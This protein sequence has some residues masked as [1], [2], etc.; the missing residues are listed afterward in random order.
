MPNNCNAM[1]WG[2]CERVIYAL[3]TRWNELT[4][5]ILAGLHPLN[6]QQKSNYS[7]LMSLDIHITCEGIITLEHTCDMA[8]Q[9][10]I[11]MIMSCCPAS[12]TS[13]TLILIKF[14]HENYRL[15]LYNCTNMVGIHAFYIHMQ[16][17]L[18]LHHW[19]YVMQCPSFSWKAE[20]AL[21]KK[22]YELI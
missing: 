1:L 16:K 13:H 17:I 5:Q 2:P 10:Y 9:K 22:Y 15:P 18:H 6:H 21:N 12:E 20:Y 19:I 3:A 4:G 7:T 11:C 14:V 8:Q